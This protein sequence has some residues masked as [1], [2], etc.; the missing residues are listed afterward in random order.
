MRARVVSAQM[1]GS[2]LILA[3]NYPARVQAFRD[4]LIRQIPRKPSTRESLAHM[5][6]L[7]TRDLI[8][9]YVNW[10]SRW[11]PAKPRKINTWLPGVNPVHL[12]ALRQELRSFMGKVTAGKDLTP[13]LSDTVRTAGYVISQPGVRAPRQDY[14]GVLT[15]YGFYHF[16]IAPHSHA[17]PKGRGKYLLFAEVSDTEFTIVALSDHD[18][19]TPGTAQAEHFH[20]MC[21]AYLERDLK[22]GE[23]LM[24]NPLL[25]SGQSLILR[26]FSDQ[27]DAKIAQVDS[28]LDDAAFIAQLWGGQPLQRHGKP[29][30]QPSHPRFRWQFNDLVFGL[31]EREAQVFFTVFPYFSR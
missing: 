10:Q 31:M 15:R 22:P 28:K 29:I 7:T 24:T 12:R 16:H 19:L 26:L 4:G 21:R 8:L 3:S 13:H 20:L 6:A 17:N 23:G 5:Q 9:A 30:R 2:E 25:S 11:L 14:D 1:P 27:C 18:A